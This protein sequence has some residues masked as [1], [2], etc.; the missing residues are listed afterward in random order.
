MI[1]WGS[2]NLG[3][4][5]SVPTPGCDRCIQKRFDEEGLGKAHDF[6][7]AFPPETRWFRFWHMCIIGIAGVFTIAAILGTMMFFLILLDG[8]FNGHY[9]WESIIAGFIGVV[10]FGISTWK[11]LLKMRYLIDGE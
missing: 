6:E 11:M 7:E 8:T 9:D 4:H 2:M 5:H 3:C 1:Q 10:I